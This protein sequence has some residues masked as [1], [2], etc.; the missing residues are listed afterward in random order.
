MGGQGIVADIEPED[1]ELA[2][3]CC[4]ATAGGVQ[5]RYINYFREGLQPSQW[6]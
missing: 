3:Q 4:G 6:C 1:W 5:N 2:G